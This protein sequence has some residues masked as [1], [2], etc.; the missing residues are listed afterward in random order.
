MYEFIKIKEYNYSNQFQ[1]IE[2][3]I[4]SLDDLLKTTQ[5][6]QYE[7]INYPIPEHL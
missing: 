4:L 1:N 2:T 6:S 5:E 7:R 3:V